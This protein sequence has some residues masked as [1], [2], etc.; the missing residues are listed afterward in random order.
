[1]QGK[2]VRW[3]KSLRRTEIIGNDLNGKDYVVKI[4]SNVY[5]VILRMA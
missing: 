5:K 4:M 1:M 3:D 2:I